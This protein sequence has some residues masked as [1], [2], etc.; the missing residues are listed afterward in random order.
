[1]HETRGGPASVHLIVYRTVHWNAIMPMHLAARSCS[2]LFFAYCQSIACSS[3]L[4]S[5]GNRVYENSER[6][7]QLFTSMHWTSEKIKFLKCLVHMVHWGLSPTKQY[8]HLLNEGVHYATMDRVACMNSVSICKCT[9]KF[10]R[11]RHLN[12]C[13][14]RDAVILRASNKAYC[15]WAYRDGTH[16]KVCKGPSKAHNMLGTLDGNAI[17]LH[18]IF[19]TPCHRCLWGV[20]YVTCQQDVLDT[21]VADV[22]GMGMLLITR[23]TFKMAW[24]KICVNEA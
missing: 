13:Y 14:M 4:I 22:C 7:E 16:D 11:V 17:E 19:P 12:T 18:A 10:L 24:F 2:H 20:K 3:L 5:M 23:G 1:M 8:N 21:W 6:L 15:L 9:R